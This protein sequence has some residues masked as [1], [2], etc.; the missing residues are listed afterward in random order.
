LNTQDSIHTEVDTTDG[1][2]KETNEDAGG[3]GDD[4]MHLD[5]GSNGAGELDPDDGPSSSSVAQS[6][7]VDLEGMYKAL[8]CIYRTSSQLGSS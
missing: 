8:L 2:N 4:D 7:V 3:V 1:S 6:A 5:T